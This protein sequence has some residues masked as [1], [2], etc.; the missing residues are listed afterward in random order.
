MAGAMFFICLVVDLRNR[1][2]TNF[3]RFGLFSKKFF[4]EAV[5]LS[6]AKDL[7]PGSAPHNLL[8]VTVASIVRFLG[9]S[10]TGI[11]SE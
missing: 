9:A 8:S 3:R 2:K 10:R 5:I 11:R 1:V 4:W 6:E 7:P